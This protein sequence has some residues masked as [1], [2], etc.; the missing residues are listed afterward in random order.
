MNDKILC[1]NPNCGKIPLI[2]LEQNSS[3]I[4]IFC[5]DHKEQIYSVND[6]L[7]ACEQGINIIC[8]ICNRKAPTNNYIF[9]CN[10]CKQYICSRCFY[11]SKCSKKGHKTEKKTNILFNNNLC[12]IHNKSYT[13]YCKQCKISLCED[14]FNNNLNHFPHDLIVIKTK[15]NNDI[16]KIGNIIKEQENSFKK[17]KQIISEYLTELE[18]KL[19]IKRIIFENYK[20][21]KLNGNALNNLDN[22]NLVIN[23]EYKNKIDTIYN[24]R[25]I[26]MNNSFKALSIDYFNKMCGSIEKDEAK[27]IEKE[28]V[29]INP[30]KK[31]YSEDNNNNKSIINIHSRGELVKS[32]FEEK[33]ICSLLALHTGNI[34]LGFS[35]GIIKVYKMDLG[36]KNIINNQYP[37]LIIERFK[38]RRINY[39]YEL[40]DKTILCCRYS[41]IHHILLNES[42]TKFTYLGTIKLSNYEIPKK[43]IELGD[44]FIVSL[45]EKKMRKENVVKTK[46]ILKIF[47]KINNNLQQNNNDDHLSDYESEQSIGSYSSDWESIY[48]NEEDNISEEEQKVDEFKEEKIVIFRKNKNMDKIYLCTIFALKTSNDQKY[49]FV[50][51]SNAKYQDGE[52]SLRFYG[53]TKN[54]FRAGHYIN[55]LDDK[56]IEKVACSQNVDSICYLEKNKIGVA[57]QNCKESEGIAIINVEKQTLERI[58]GGL[59]LGIIKINYINNKKN[60]F[61]FTNGSKKAEKLDQFG[62]YEYTERHKLLVY[63]ENA[64]SNSICSLRKGILGCSELKDNNRNIYYAIYTSNEVFILK[65]K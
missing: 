59:T 58:I 17:V 57:L 24:N 38:G 7:N 45:G 16:D 28:K 29:N 51:S 22:L 23:Q 35:S 55:Y 64:N 18:N 49:Q 6:Y 31:F 60:I 47:K 21:N 52:N 27:N 9:F 56:K 33:N 48:S 62:I 40:K 30:N 25:D 5:S 1:P 53:M 26:D 11:N 14:C 13:K 32:I 8:S 61:F 20:K 10:I 44:K 42:D 54:P 2:N 4:K 12:S 19:K 34:A 36:N 46:S 41:K 63:K 3:Y 65:I 43:I 37:L 39:L 50:A 15:T